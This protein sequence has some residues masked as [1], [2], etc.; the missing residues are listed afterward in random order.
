[1]APTPDEDRAAA[2]DDVAEAREEREARPELL[3]RARKLLSDHDEE[4]LEEMSNDEI[5]KLLVVR[6]TGLE[7]KRRESDSKHY[8][9]GAYEAA[10]KQAAAKKADAIIAERARADARPEPDLAGAKAVYMA[11]LRGVPVTTVRAE[12]TRARLDQMD[13]DEK[14]ERARAQ[15]RLDAAEGQRFL[16]AYDKALRTA[17]QRRQDEAEREIAEGEAAW[18][19]ALERE[20]AKLDARCGPGPDIDAARRAFQKAV[21]GR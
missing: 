5:R 21:S 7:F 11:K 12:E 19:Q 9:R 14:L 3:A 15:D 2:V 20:Q 18:Q 10:L 6:M 16:E 13:Y 1:V 8:I 4:G 17:A